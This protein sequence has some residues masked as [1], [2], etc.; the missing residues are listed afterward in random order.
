MVAALALVICSFYLLALTAPAAGMFHDDGV[1]LVTAKSLAEGRG[2][3]LLSMPGEPPQTKYPV[4]FPFSLSS[5]AFYISSESAV[6]GRSACR[7]GGVAVLVWRLLNRW[8]FATRTRAD[9]C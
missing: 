8:G 6:A 1:Y 9:C 2:Y 5:G 7:D 4:L 3:R